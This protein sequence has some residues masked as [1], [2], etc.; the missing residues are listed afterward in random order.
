[1]DKKEDALM[2]FTK[3]TKADPKNAK[4]WNNKGFVL[5]DLNRKDLAL[6]AYQKAIKANP[7][8]AR[9]IE[10]MGRLLCEM[11][12]SEEAIIAYLKALDSNSDNLQIRHNLGRLLFTLK[13]TTDA[14]KQF[15]IVLESGEN[16]H[17][18]LNLGHCILIL[19]NR[20]EAIKNYKTSLDLWNYSHEFFVD[21]DDD[22]Q[23]IEPQ[24]VS[25]EEYQKIKTELQQYCKD[26]KDSRT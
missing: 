23:H 25:K 13:Q 17:A 15:E 9:A 14:K 18:Y 11:E 24:G 16:K 5:N 26:K 7:K 1:M 10:N 20:K 8:Y 4:A 12:K 22:F 2:S 6:K 19:E 3:A 21:F